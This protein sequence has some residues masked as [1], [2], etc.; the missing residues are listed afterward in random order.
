MAERLPV[1]Y[2]TDVLFDVD[3]KNKDYAILDLYKK[4]NE[5]K[6]LATV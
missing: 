6:I 2:D 5:R 3:L 1:Y 4:Y